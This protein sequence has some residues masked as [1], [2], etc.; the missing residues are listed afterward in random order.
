MLQISNTHKGG[1]VSHAHTFHLYFGE[2]EILV[3]YYGPGLVKKFWLKVVKI[4]KR[5][6][7]S[8]SKT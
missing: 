4:S 8:T 3:Q 7:K 1:L 2:F 6:R 5:P